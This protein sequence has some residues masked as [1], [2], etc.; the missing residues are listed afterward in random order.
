MELFLI[1]QSKTCNKQWV[2]T[3]SFFLPKQKKI[4]FKATFLKNTFQRSVPDCKGHFL[5]MKHRNRWKDSCSQNASVK[6]NRV[7]AN[8]FRYKNMFKKK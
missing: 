4:W 8:P 1:T 3:V 2:G 5:A 6:T 7:L